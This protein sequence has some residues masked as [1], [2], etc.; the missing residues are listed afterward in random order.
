MSERWSRDISNTLKEDLSGR[1]LK[2]P[3]ETD[4]KCQDVNLLICDKNKN[5]LD[6]STLVCVQSLLLFT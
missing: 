2:H 4:I 5:V 1:F 3:Q 6:G